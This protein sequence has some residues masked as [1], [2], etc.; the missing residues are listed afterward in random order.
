[1]TIDDKPSPA[2]E[3]NPPTDS[4]RAARVSAFAETRAEKS[5]AG[6]ESHLS[7][8]DRATLD[9][10]NAFDPRLAG[11]FRVGLE[12]LPRL[13]EP[14]VP[15]LV[16]HAGREIANGVER[17]LAGE[18]QPSSGEAE[19][20]GGEV[21][22]N[23]IRIGAIL[24]LPP[25]HELVRMWFR[26]RRVFSNSCHFDANPL[27][28]RL[29][30]AF[31][32]FAE[33]LFG[34]VGPYF[35]THAELD[36][37]LRIERP[38]RA[39]VEMAARLLLRPQQRHHFF[40]ALAN[41]LWLEPLA[42]SGQFASPPD[43]DVKADGSWSPRAW[44][45]G[46][47]LTRLASTHPDAVARVLSQIPGAN[48]NPAVW[49][50][51]MSAALAM[52][53]R[54]AASLVPSI[55]GAL[56]HDSGFTLAHEA[57]R[58]VQHL[59]Q[60]GEQA[61]FDLADALLWFVKLKRPEQSEPAGST[62]PSP[63]AIRRQDTAWLLPRL[64]DWD[65]R[66]F[67]ERAVPSLEGLDPV[68]TC[69]LLAPKLRRAVFLM[70]SVLPEEVR[71]DGTAR[72]CKR[73]TT[74]STSKD[75]RA[76]LACA[77]AAVASRAAPVGQEQARSVFALLKCDGEIFE[78]LRWTVLASAGTFL[79]AELDSV[80]GS[81]RLVAPPFGAAEAAA[82][83]RAQFSHASTD[84]RRL[85]TYALE[86]GPT[87]EALQR[88]IAFRR[89]RLD[90]Q[91]ST[92][93]TLPELEMGAVVNDWRARRLRWFHDLIPPEL[94]AMA[95][96]AGVSPA[97]PSAERQDLDELGWHTATGG[98]RIRDATLRTAAELDAAEAADTAR[99]LREW[100]GPDESFGRGPSR[101]GLE[102]ALTEFAE[103]NPA[104]ALEVAAYFSGQPIPLNYLAALLAGVQAAVRSREIPWKEAL[105][106]VQS[107]VTLASDRELA[108]EERRSWRNPGRATIATAL[109]VLREACRT[110]KL[111]LALAADAWAFVRHAL[112]SPAVWH[113]EAAEDPERFGDVLDAS[114]NSLSGAAVQTLLEFA[115]WHYRETVRERGESVADEPHVD[116]IEVR[117]APLLS[118]IIEHDGTAAQRARAMLGGYVPQVYLLAPA[119]AT[120]N[121]NALFANGATTPLLNP[122]WG[123]YLARGGFFDAVFTRLRAWYVSA[124]DATAEAGDSLSAE[125][126][127]APSRGLAD[128]VLIAI[129]RGLAQLGDSDSLVERTFSC[130]TSGPK[131]EVY[132]ALQADW[133]DDRASVPP[134]FVPRLV[135][136]WEW[137]LTELERALGR[138]DA[139]V[140]AEAV[141]L[142]PLASLPQFEPSDA[143]R[144][145]VRTVR[146][147]PAAEDRSSAPWES[148]E[149]LAAADAVGSFEL[150]E[151]LVARALATRFPYLPF[152][153]LAPPLRAAL[154]CPDDAVRRR[155]TR[156][157]N[158]LGERGFVEYG[159]L[160][161]PAKG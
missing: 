22:G 48:S 31:E 106:V 88:T 70:D 68:A 24:G 86:R 71:G 19:T 21:E 26:E 75:V 11:L 91:G 34:R 59:A 132:W 107:A 117:L 129:V 14:G 110:S 95:T 42:S 8:R 154:A 47:Y 153:K 116:E 140:Q 35:D 124:A 160:L 125:R 76:A 92:T 32:N 118:E 108:Q 143:I 38:T 114:L 28:D 45:Q 41:P 98:E 157:I 161:A 50:A 10:L 39:H 69:A 13:S 97:V 131:A 53:A 126:R 156:L 27:P 112:R 93:D 54:I 15:Y 150:V 49:N 23:R 36:A 1:M 12:L 9:E 46:Q 158:I 147:L 113:E 33:L 18:A 20:D 89:E 74:S 109:Q 159:A 7:N 105:V 5:L 123:A 100:T 146:L 29:R 58:V 51:V 43:R 136:F 60:G 148:L 101:S 66:E 80:I 138:S 78:R 44:P 121:E 137:R 142:L 67:I 55:Q 52:P 139:E 63:A 4:S 6:F 134:G 149:R 99:L 104:K 133:G 145:G 81:D 151:P 155:A 56:K 57:A 152:D 65:L 103:A 62:G 30:E 90:Q 102:E 94:Q 135:V 120:A 84:A 2:L 119:W 17:I 40:S 3:A 115:L 72:W 85:F 64:N 73:V 87:P 25:D 122:V 128:H 61:A 130:V 82:L 79:Q 83:L 141:A 96:A 111:P 77:L 144:L 37:L 16:A 127:W